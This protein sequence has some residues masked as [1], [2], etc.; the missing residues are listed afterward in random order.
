MFSGRFGDSTGRPYVEGRLTIPRLGIVGNISFLA[1]TGADT[2][3]LM[4][5]D[6]GK[7][8]L[9]YSQ[10]K[11]KAVSVGVGG[12]SDNFIEQAWVTFNNGQELVS[13]SIYLTILQPSKHI[14]D[15]PS[16]L[17]RDILDKCRM[18]YNPLDKELLFEPK[19]ADVTTPIKSQGTA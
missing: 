19:I 16:L 5:M 17:G 4:P 10:L 11:D 8:G 1:D 9:D 3:C 14:G 13:Y 18:I 2:T 12:K 6:A 7:V 15:I